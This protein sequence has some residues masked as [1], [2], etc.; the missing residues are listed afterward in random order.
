M[1]NFITLIGK[2]LKPGG[3]Q[4]ENELL[5]QSKVFCMAPWIQ[6]H[7][8]THGEVT[9]C[10]VSAY[11]GE[12]VGNLRTDANLSH[13]WNSAAMKKLRQNMLNGTASNMC[14]NCYESEALGKSSDREQY[15]RDYVSYFK[16][17]EN[18]LSDGTVTDNTIPILDIRF[19][20]KCNYKCRICNSSN[21][22]QLY[23]E[24]LKLG[25]ISTDKPKEYKVTSNEDA[26]WKSY[27]ALLPGVT[28][29]HFAGGEP[30][31]M[32][33]HYRALE[34]LIAIGKT[35]VTLSYN[36][37][38]STLRYK[39]YHLV[40]L[41]QKFE[42]VEVWASLD[43]MGAQGDY[44]R[45]GQKWNDIE[46][47]IRTLQQQCPHVLLGIDVTA[48]ILNIFSIPAFYQYMVQQRFVNP[49]RFNLYFLHE[50]DYFNVTNL[51]PT[52]PQ[53]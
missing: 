47:N 13:A 2:K 19:S 23:E 6:L 46:Q 39:Q 24:D 4:K 35:N 37:N 51:T 27:S 25:K 52:L 5:H 21:S 7:A 53:L 26:F 30:L 11:K 16:R 43:A 22:T 33:E 34:H 42:R 18:T 3:S 20:N 32:E 28:K 40:E 12:C 36:T 49:E 14:G 10:C 41:W 9:P 45:K 44:Q 38:F 8:Q 31:I 29:L 48:S 15:N 1:L 50:P 17:V